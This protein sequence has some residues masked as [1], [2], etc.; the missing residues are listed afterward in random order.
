MLKAKTIGFLGAGNMAE[1]L[2]QGLIHAGLTR[3]E[4]ILVANRQNADR[5]ATLGLRLGVRTTA[6]RRAVA[7]TADILVVAC[8]PK[9]VADLLAEVG[10]L[11]RAGQVLLSLA[12]GIPTSALAEGVQPGVQ[13]VRSMPNTSCLVRES[14]TAICAGPGTGR[15]AMMLASAILS[16]VG[17]VA[18]VA[19]PLM[20]AVTGLSG[21]GPAYIYYVVETMIRAGSELGLTDEVAREL[22]LQ[23]V[24]GAARM[25]METGSDPA[26][27]RHKVTSPNGTTAAAMQLLTEHHFSDTLVAAIHRAAERSAEMG[28]T[29]APRPAGD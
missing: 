27:L 12:A 4:Q 15:E 7:R 29:L 22:A 19:E 25:L 24:L 13:V 20:D 14:A 9:D 18:E 5:L 11:T 8:K 10:S 26:V 23:T 2:M 6:D 1:A 21:T 16:A 17:T 3:P 28:R